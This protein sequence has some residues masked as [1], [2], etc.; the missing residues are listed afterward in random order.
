MFASTSPF[1]E[2]LKAA[3]IPSLAALVAKMNTLNVFDTVFY[4]PSLADDIPFADRFRAVI[5]IHEAVHNSGE[6]MIGLSIAIP[7]R[8]DGSMNLSKKI[9]EACFPALNSNGYFGRLTF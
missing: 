9:A 7:G 8:G 5:L 4:D 6:K 2:A 3:G 1:D